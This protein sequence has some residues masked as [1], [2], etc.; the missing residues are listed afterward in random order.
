MQ[1]L[2]EQLWERSKEGR[3]ETDREPSTH[4]RNKAWETRPG[5]TGKTVKARADAAHRGSHCEAE[6]GS[7]ERKNSGLSSQNRNRSGRKKAE[8]KGKGRKRKQKASTCGTAVGAK[9]GRMKG[10][11][12]RAEYENLEGRHERSG[13]REQGKP[14]KRKRKGRL[15]KPL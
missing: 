5:R 6:P 4:N 8:G 12:Q 14:K 11:E 7:A 2:A 9:Q 15:K 3:K 13:W 10:N 1:A